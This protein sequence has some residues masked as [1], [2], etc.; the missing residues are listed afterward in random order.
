[1]FGRI[2]FTLMLQR[3]FDIAVVALF[4]LRTGYGAHLLVMVVHKKMRSKKE[5]EEADRRTERIFSLLY[6]KSLLP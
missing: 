4:S 5:R 2:E 3:A 6:Q 1:M